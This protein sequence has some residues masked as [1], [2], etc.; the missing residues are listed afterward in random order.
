MPKPGAAR[1]SR[2]PPKP[3]LIPTGVSDMPDAQPEILALIQRKIET[4]E[5]WAEAFGKLL[6][7]DAVEQDGAVWDLLQSVNSSISWE[8]FCAENA[9]AFDLRA[10][11]AQQEAAAGQTLEL[12]PDTLGY[13]RPVS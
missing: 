5:M 13:A 9:P 12:N 3:G 8:A 4:D 10:R 1:H 6:T 11:K 2:P 7:V